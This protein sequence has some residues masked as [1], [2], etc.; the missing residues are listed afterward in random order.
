M[1]YENYNQAIVGAKESMLDQIR[2]KRRVFD[3]YVL[4]QLPQSRD[5]AI[6]DCGCGFGAYLVCLAET[7]YRNAT[8]IDLSADQIEAAIREFGLAN[9]KV[10]DVVSYLEE[11]DQKWDIVLM[12]DLI[13]HLPVELSVRMLT[14][15]RA[16]LKD[17]GKVI[18]MTPNAISPFSPYLYGDI[19]HLRAYTVASLTQ[20]ARLAGF[21][22]T[23][24]QGV[25]PIPVTLKT[26]IQALLGRFFF[27]PLIRLFCKSYFG[28]DLW[29]I[30]SANLICTLQ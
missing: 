25:E 7:G 5:A 3:R 15:A 19:T 14:S 27:R 8:G 1:I 2:Y 18:L 17:G 4:P 30:Y 21:G 9:A 28:W 6:L 29:G 12:M 11:S 16:R 10:G 23:V 26:R 20:S 24:V 22:K 13:E